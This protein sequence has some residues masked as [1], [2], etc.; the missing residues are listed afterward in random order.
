MYRR[1]RGRDGG[2]TGTSIRCN[3][4]GLGDH[5]TVKAHYYNGL[6]KLLSSII[7]MTDIYKIMSDRELAVKAVGFMMHIGVLD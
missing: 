3:S 4:G 7:T 5:A 1:Y 2:S 6:P